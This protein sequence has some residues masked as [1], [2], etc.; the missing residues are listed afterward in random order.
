MER[1]KL[2][3][4][5]APA[6]GHTIDI[7]V[8]G[9]IGEGE[10]AILGEV[11]LSVGLG[12]LAHR[13]LDHVVGVFAVGLC[14]EVGN[15]HLFHLFMLFDGGFHHLRG[16]VILTALAHE[17]DDVAHF[18]TLGLEVFCL[19][20]KDAARVVFEGEIA[21]RSIFNIGHNA[22]DAILRAAHS[23]FVE[24]I[25]GGC[26]DGSRLH[27]LGLCGIGFAAFG[28]AERK[29]GASVAAGIGLCGELHGRFGRGGLDTT[30]GEPTFGIVG[31]INRNAL[32]LANQ[33]GREST[34]G[35]GE[36]V[37]FNGIDLDE[38]L[39][40]ADEGGIFELSHA[41][42]GGA[43]PFDGHFVAYFDVKRLPGI[44]AAGIFRA[45]DVELAGAVV[46]IEVAI[47]GVVDR[48]AGSGDAIALVVD[49]REDFGTGG[50]R[51]GRQTLNDVDVLRL[52]VRCNNHFG[53]ATV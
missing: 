7:D 35:Y 13:S 17:G 38:R 42:V 22:R 48:N 26:N 20:N 50:F 10:V 28:G 2:A 9:G 3:F 40:H 5:S 6:R 23:R 53:R 45:I 18:H 24:C 8:A 47:G 32:P 14:A 33:V 25:D 4:L 37:V 19:I 39:F 21:L 31:N 36:R 52:A 30:D 44:V 15:R 29:G 1:A 16:G 12:R 11:E 27:Q 46:E 34:A 49:A 41:V 51:N 43:W